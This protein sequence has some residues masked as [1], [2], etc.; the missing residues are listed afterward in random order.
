VKYVVLGGSSFYGKSF[1]KLLKDN[2]EE[3]VSLSRPSFDLSKDFRLPKSDIVV[4]FIAEGLVEES[5]ADPERWLMT[6]SVYT[7][8]LFDDL[9]RL[10]NTLYVHVST[11]EVYGSVSNWVAENYPYNPSTPYAVSRACG[12]MMLEAYHK[13]FGMKMIITRTANIYG[14]GQQDFRLIPK[15]FNYFSDKRP[16]PIHGQGYSMR[17]WIDV[18]DAC[19]GLYTVCKHG[20][21]GDTYH[22]STTELKNVT[23]ILSNIGY[24]VGWQEYEWKPERL[25]KDKHYFLDSTKL[26]ALGWSDKITLKEGL[27]AYY[28]AFNERSKRVSVKA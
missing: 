5:W 4:N 22:I 12:D 24:I 15:A 19:E 21:V 1:T 18:R 6:N 28:A 2:G 27:N 8:R 17:S 23:E 11:P 9:K 26:R 10:P 20:K 25:G 3:V 13:A 16:F 14:W 7:T